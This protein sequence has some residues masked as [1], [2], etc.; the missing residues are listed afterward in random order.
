MKKV[1]SMYEKTSNSQTKGKNQFKR[2]S[3]PINFISTKW[4]H[5]VPRTHFTL[6]FSEEKDTNMPNNPR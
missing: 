1:P 3:K 5:L 6:P 4:F 2:L